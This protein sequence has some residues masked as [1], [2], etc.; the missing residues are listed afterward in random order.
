MIVK[1]ATATLLVGCAATAGGGEPEFGVCRKDVIRFVQE[2]LGQTVKRV[3]IKA[4]A[5]R[6][7]P[8]HFDTG[9]VLA[10]VEECHGFHSFELIGTWSECEHLPHYGTN[11]SYIIYEGPFGGCRSS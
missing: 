5:D 6:S 8:G 2:E 7:T 3:D 1:V 10:F 9:N 4:Y 11:R